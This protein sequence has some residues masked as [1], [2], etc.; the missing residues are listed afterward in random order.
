MTNSPV[1][2]YTFDKQKVLNATFLQITSLDDRQNRLLTS[3][4]L[5]D[6]NLEPFKILFAF[7]MQDPQFINN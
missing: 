3:V 7:K 6:L 2:T 5:K 4:G 1:P